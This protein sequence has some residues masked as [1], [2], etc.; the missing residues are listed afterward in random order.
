MDC[1]TVAGNPHSC[2]MKKRLPRAAGVSKPAR[3][4]QFRRNAARRDAPDMDIA[5]DP[6]ERTHA[7]LPPGTAFVDTFVIDINGVP[8]GKRLAASEWRGAASRVGFSA[9]ALVLDARGNAQG[10]LG[11]GT[12]DGDPDGFGVPVPG[13]VASVPWAQAPVA[14]SLLSMR[15]AGEPLWF[16]TRQI[17]ADIVSRCHADGLF[18]VVACELEFYLL[19][20]GADGRPVPPVGGTPG[21]GHL[22]PQQVEAH[23]ALLHELHAALGV[24]GVAAGTLVAEYGPGQFEVNL[25]H[26]PDPLAAADE[27]VLL[28]RAA[29]GVAARHGLR[30]SFMA[31]PYARHPGNGLHVHVSLVDAAGEN[32][33]G[34]TGGQALLEHAI[35]GMQALHAESMALFAPSFSAYRRLRGGSFVAAGGSWGENSR[36]VAFRIPP[37]GAASRRIEHRVACADASPHLVMAA[38]LAALHYGV[39]RKISP[40]P[41]VAAPTN[42]FAALDALTAGTRLAEYLPPRFPALF[43]ALKAAEARDVLEEPSAGELEYYL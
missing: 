37:G 33:F 39:T 10:P 40:G 19:R 11:I 8:R 7:D 34:A 28:R 1:T 35:G 36:A 5:A 4:R 27:A 25:A 15:A 16:D 21:G 2:D 30:A 6:T 17:L 12:E 3:R 31:K 9:S 38:I 13:R 42:I 20:V 18:P 23:G 26:G 24:Q 32:R 22:S 14:Q 43:G 41:A 29:Q